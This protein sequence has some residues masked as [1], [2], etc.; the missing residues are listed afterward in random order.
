M[1]AWFGLGCFCGGINLTVFCMSYLIF[2]G[3]LVLVS[4]VIIGI[5]ALSVQY[6]DAPF[7]ST[8]EA[9]NCI[10]YIQFSFSSYTSILLTLTLLSPHILPHA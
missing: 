5:Y 6:D 10:T 2:V 1:G 3:V 8:V 9:V 4:L 7:Y